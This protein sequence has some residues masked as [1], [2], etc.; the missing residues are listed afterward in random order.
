MAETTCVLCGKAAAFQWSDTHGVAAEI[1]CGMPYRLY[2]YDT[3]N[4]RLD[5]GPEPITLYP[6]W[7][8]IGKRYHTETGRRAFPAS[9]DM[10][11]GRGGYS[12]SGA[13]PSD[14]QVWDDWLTAHK[15]ELPKPPEEPA[16]PDAPATPNIG[17]GKA[18][19]QPR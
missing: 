8:E 2:H 5:K 12:Y 1:H 6:G 13:S 15:D 7:L 14:I 19:T 9:F 4:K 10:G 18:E 17:D 16:E 11:I 3:E